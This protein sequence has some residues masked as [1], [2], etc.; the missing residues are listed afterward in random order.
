MAKNVILEQVRIRG[1]QTTPDVDWLT[2]EVDP[3]DPSSLSVRARPGS[4]EQLDLDLRN[5]GCPRCGSLLTFGFRHSPEE[6]DE[7]LVR[8]VLDS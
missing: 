7:A 2:V 3:V 4:L 8:D 6:C 5:R 1:L